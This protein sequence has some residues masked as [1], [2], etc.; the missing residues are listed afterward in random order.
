MSS[1]PSN[2]K[3]RPAD[4][5]DLALF[6]RVLAELCRSEVPLPR[7]FAILRAE[8]ARGP[9]RSAVDAMAEETGNGVPLAE[10]YAKRPDSWVPPRALKR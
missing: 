8:F 9:L 2:T 6:H 10:A 4:G 5:D 1:G 7:A 3:V